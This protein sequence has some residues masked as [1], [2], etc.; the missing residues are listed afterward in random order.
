MFKKIFFV[1]VLI[2]LIGCAKRGSIDGGAKDTLAPVLKLSFP[3]NGSINFT[4]KE[5]KLTF[6]EYIKLKGVEKQLIISPPFKQIPE[7]TPTIASKTI[8][9]KI[10]DTL[11]PNTTYSLNFGQSIE[12]NNESNAYKQFKYVFSTGGH[13]DSL[14]LGG[15]I[16]DAI[17][18]K[19]DNFVSVMLYEVNEKFN[20]SVIYKQNPRYIT[21]TLDSLKTFRIENIKA[22]K[23]LLVAI[24]DKNGNNKFNS[25][26]EKIGYQKQFIT[27]PNDTVFQLELFK[28]RLP[29]KAFKPKQASGNRILLPYEGNGKNIKIILKNGT[30]DLPIKT[31]FVDKKDSLN[32]WFSPIKADSLHLNVANEKY[33]ENF[34]VKMK[35]QKKD[36]LRFSA[37]QTGV[38]DFRDVFTIQSSN[39]ISKIDVSKIKFVNKDSVAVAYKI[40]NDSDILNLKFDFKK[41]PNEKYKINI[42]PGAFVDYL[43]QKNDSLE[44]KFNTKDLIDYGNLRVVLQNVRKFPILVELTDSKGDVMA[45]VVSN[46]ET[47]LDFNLIEPKKY[48]LRVVYDENNNGEWDEGNYLEKRQSEEVIYFPKKI[49]VRANWDVEQIFDLNF[50]ASKK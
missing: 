1:L 42:L 48:N 2:L 50:N 15:T 46:K 33:A 40:K 35:N 43:E 30:T 22:G 24:K 28:E 19:T 45:N 31:S 4:G 17:S 44:F 36:S 39:P 10:K 27:I 12:D 47:T 16:K 29:F 14:A 49:D 5:I 11:L 7:I 37:K 21:N 6:D 3:K 23:Y 41:E 32:V 9:I 25:R 18:K 38:L 13:I 8:T 20:D 26:E 34:Y